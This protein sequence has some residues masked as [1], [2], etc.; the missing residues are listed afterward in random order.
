MTERTGDELNKIGTAVDVQISSVRLD[1]SQQKPVTT[2]VVRHGDNLYIRS[3]K[4]RNGLT[5]RRREG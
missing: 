4:G 3:V 2:W 1:G 5:F